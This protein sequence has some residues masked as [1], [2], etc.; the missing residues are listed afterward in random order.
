MT[1]EGNRPE[2][3]RSCLKG[4]EVARTS[5]A[6]IILNATEVRAVTFPESKN[7]IRAKIHQLNL[8]VIINK[9]LT[10]L[11]RWNPEKYYK[12]RVRIIKKTRTTD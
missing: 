2:D 1:G 3:I 11:Y 9:V 7:R 12:V 8:F 4:E 10:T 6:I 5:A